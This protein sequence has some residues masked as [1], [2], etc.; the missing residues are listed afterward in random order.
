METDCFLWCINYLFTGL[1]H[2]VEFH[3]SSTRS[4]CSVVL[5]IARAN[6]QVLRTFQDALRATFAGLSIPLSEFGVN[7]EFTRARHCPCPE[8]ARFSHTTTP[9][10][11]TIHFNIIISS[12][13][14]S[15][16]WSLSLRFPH[17]NPVYTNKQIT[18]LKWWLNLTND[19]KGD[20]WRSNQSRKGRHG[21]RTRVLR[22]PIVFLGVCCSICVLCTSSILILLI[23]TLRCSIVRCNILILLKNCSL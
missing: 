9:H 15:P 21:M 22:R 16:Q 13:S 11:L 12:Q 14:V 5:I 7:A 23:K 19:N 10:F 18:E 4:W 20:D 8:S 1:F 2:L 3:T 17:Q 6:A